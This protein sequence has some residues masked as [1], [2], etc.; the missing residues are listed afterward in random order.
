METMSAVIE[1]FAWFSNE[2]LFT[3]ARLQQLGMEAENVATEVKNMY[4]EW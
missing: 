4:K 3:N 1:R 2:I